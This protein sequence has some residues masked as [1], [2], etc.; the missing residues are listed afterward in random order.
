M[1]ESAARVPGTNLCFDPALLVVEPMKIGPL[2]GAMTRRGLPCRQDPVMGGPGGTPRNGRCHWH[3]RKS[4]G[5]KTAQGKAAI[6]ASNRRRA[7]RRKFHTGRMPSPPMG[8]GG[9]TPGLGRWF[10]LRRSAER[11]P[12]QILAFRSRPGSIR[13]ATARRPGGAAR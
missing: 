13:R 2:C 9:G 10:Q 4:T 11:S 3:G 5:P 6:A 8:R 7:E 1:S 12:S